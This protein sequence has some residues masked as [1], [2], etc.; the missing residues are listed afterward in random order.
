MTPEQPAGH[1]ALAGGVAGIDALRPLLDVALAALTTGATTRGGPLPP[2]GPAG[3]AAE[4]ARVLGSEVA[5][6]GVVGLDA[7]AAG[8]G[9]RGGLRPVMGAVGERGGASG[10]GEVG[11]G[12]ADSDP[13]GALAVLAGPGDGSPVVDVPAG[14]AVWVLGSEV[15][16][17][18]VVGLDASAAGAGARGGLRPVM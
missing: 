13:T 17:S 2:G 11:S 10:L 1:A 5:G 4:V 15:A 14:G 12:C 18:G 8:A 6:S 9:A 16:G 7:S 3:V